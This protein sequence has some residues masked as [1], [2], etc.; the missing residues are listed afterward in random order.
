MKTKMELKAA[1]KKEQNRLI[2]IAKTKGIYEE[3]GHKE[4]RKL[5]SKFVELSNYSIENNEKRRL[6]LNFM[7]WCINYTG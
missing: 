6:I 5:Y 2:R 4:V 7:K 3:F 1:I